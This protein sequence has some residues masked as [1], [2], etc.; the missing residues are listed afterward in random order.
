MTVCYH[1]FRLINQYLFKK[2]FYNMNSGLN[3]PAPKELA[4]KSSTRSVSL[5]VNENTYL[6]FEKYAV[7][8]NI[9]V[10]ALINNLL[11]SYVENLNLTSEQSK[12]STYEIMKDAL[13][14]SRVAVNALSKE[15]L[16]EYFYGIMCRYNRDTPTPQ[17]TLQMLDDMNSNIETGTYSSIEFNQRGDSSYITI[18]CD[19]CERANISDEEDKGRHVSIPHKIWLPVAF[20]LAKY[21]RKLDELCV[22]SDDFIGME[23]E[24]TTKTIKEIVENVNLYI[25]KCIDIDNLMQII[26]V[27]LCQDF[28]YL[29]DAEILHAR[30]TN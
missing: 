5:R 23:T 3:L 28:R 16:A 10:S 8:Y 15:R 22:T 25:D 26:S 14:A 6:S 12:E 1:S 2:E 4:R 27:V 24:I 11:D 7:Q 13:K 9:T 17:E 19:N 29:L 18:F 30:N 21:L 20:I